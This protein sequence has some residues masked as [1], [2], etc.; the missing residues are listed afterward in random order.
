MIER[1]DDES[2]RQLLTLQPKSGREECWYLPFCLLLTPSETLALGKVLPTFRVNLS[3]SL[4][5][6]WSILLD[7]P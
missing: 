1:H 5:S 7:M 2:M 4:K 6:L 3:S